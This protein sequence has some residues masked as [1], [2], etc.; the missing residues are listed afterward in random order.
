MRDKPDLNRIH[1]IPNDSEMKK[2]RKRRS[3]FD[4]QNSYC[5]IIVC[6]HKNLKSNLTTDYGRIVD[7]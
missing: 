3:R 6:S 7:F 5:G 4:S 2:E 1:S